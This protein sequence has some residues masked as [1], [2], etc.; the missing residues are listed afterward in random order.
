MRVI[1]SGLFE[2]ETRVHI[3][4]CLDVSHCWEQCAAQM[5]VIK[6]GNGMLLV[7]TRAGNKLAFRRSSDLANWVYSVFAPVDPVT[8]RPARKTRDFHRAFIKY[9]CERLGELEPP[10]PPTY[11]RRATAAAL[12]LAVAVEFD[13]GLPA[14]LSPEDVA[15]RLAYALPSRDA[16]AAAESLL[17][18]LENGEVRGYTA[19][20]TADGKFTVEK[21]SDKKPTKK[22]AVEAFV[23][24][25]ASAVDF[26]AEISS[27]DAAHLAPRALPRMRGRPDLVAKKML[28]AACELDL[29]GHS[30]ARIGK[31]AFRLYRK[32][33]Q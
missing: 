30:V 31:D 21:A 28:L 14:T 29:E 4:T 3:L 5:R 11:V 24:A 1:Q 17:K 12:D 25:L 13:L 15:V 32:E 33:A 22:D 7:E 6:L 20:R 27:A 26:P 9:A 2:A 19:T 10:P 23:S 16:P 18:R 8:R